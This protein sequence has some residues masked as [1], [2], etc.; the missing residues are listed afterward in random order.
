VMKFR[1]QQ[2]NA[3][4]AISDEKVGK[5][6]IR[7]RCKKCGEL[8]TVRPVASAPEESP[9]MSPPADLSSKEEPE[10]SNET[11]RQEDR[12]QIA[13][14][15]NGETAGLEAPAS[16][17]AGTGGGE[18]ELGSAFSN[19]FHEGALDGGGEEQGEQEDEE[20]S[21]SDRQSTRIFNVE[22]MQRVAAEREKAQESDEEPKRSDG[23]GKPSFGRA[24]PELRE[25]LAASG[26]D[27]AD[28][29]AEWY[30]AIGDQQ[31]GPMA[32]SELG[33]RFDQKEINPETLVWKSGFE[34]WIPLFETKELARLV[35]SR[36]RKPAKDSFEGGGTEPR[37]RTAEENLEERQKES[38]LGAEESS[39]ASSA[40]FGADVDWKPSAISALGS[41]AQEE[42][43]GLKPVDPEPPP[44]PSIPEEEESHEAG[45]VAETQEEGDGSII[46]QIAAEEAAAANQAEE[47][48]LL[49][50]QQEKEAARKAET[51]A[52]EKEL[53]RQRLLERQATSV[54]P[55][56]SAIGSRPS[57]PGWAI[58]VMS[59][60][61]MLIV[62]L[63]AFMAYKFAVGNPAGGV[64]ALPVVPKTVTQP[65]P[66]SA[67]QP[68]V[69]PAP[70]P[71][72]P[73]PGN[74]VGTQ[75]AATPQPANVAPAVAPVA[76]T[77]ALPAVNT[78]SVETAPVKTV[79]KNTPRGLDKPPKLPPV[80]K[81]KPNPIDSIDEKPKEPPPEEAPAHKKKG[82][83][84]GLLDFEDGDEDSAA[85]KKE[86]GLGG[87]TAEKKSEAKELPPLSTA[88]V[89]GVMKQHLA[90]FQAC[91]RKHIESGDDAVK[92]KM[93]LEFIITPDGAVSKIATTTPEFKG[94]IVSDCISKVVQS[95]RFPKFGGEPNKRV[96]FPFTVK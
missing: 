48:R 58:G 70:Q 51:L 57:L 39:S 29:P 41:L 52:A 1:C 4:Y 85:L 26:D 61:G 34:N 33:R 9:K 63:V 68:V 27:T 67:V 90:E 81:K 54:P 60:G 35:E 40:A 88:D 3:Q 89:M 82:G 38:F 31:L 19:L 43:A 17:T 77:P 49:E 64:V 65:E 2:C 25:E 15:P 13:V 18:D 71:G 37:G 11:A 22:E 12:T 95:I 83:G 73:Q 10:E 7:V 74:P 36:E 6:G 14:S 96:P 47:K 32:V 78:A 59:G 46:A 62:V 79:V 30:V 24:E 75:P 80:E 8:I 42:L 50:E 55:A 28:G 76:A 21:D 72:T 86:M 53:E 20:E 94:T 87:G 44:E 56:E 66:P 93:V 69:A 84:K 16:R 92:G 23:A 91:T 5:K 45:G